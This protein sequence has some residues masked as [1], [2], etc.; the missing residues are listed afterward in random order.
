M[1]IENG[2]IL[3][4]RKALYGLEQAPRL[5]YMR[6][7]EYR[8]KLQFRMSAFDS[9]VFIHE[10]NLLIVAIWVDDLLILARDEQSATTT[11]G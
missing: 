6:L 8:Y 7:T 3:G 11:W 5:W 1:G 2:K 10:E 4:P 9:C